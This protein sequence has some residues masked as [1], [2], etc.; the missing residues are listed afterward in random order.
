MR[1]LKMTYHFSSNSHPKPPLP[2]GISPLVLSLVEVLVLSLVEVRET[3]CFGIEFIIQVPTGPLPLPVLSKVEVL[4]L[5][6]VE[7]RKGLGMGVL[8]S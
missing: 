2:K 4:V 8:I 7:V 1:D 5:S 3:I 6:L